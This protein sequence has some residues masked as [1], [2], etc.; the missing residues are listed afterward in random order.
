[1]IVGMSGRTML[2]TS[3]FRFD[4][5]FRKSG[6]FD[7]DCSIEITEY[8]RDGESRLKIKHGTE[9]LD[10]PND[11]GSQDLFIAWAKEF[12]QEPE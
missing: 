2:I 5:T 7:A 10:V 6:C 12:H 11:H 9:E 8:D 1:M 3:E 4:A